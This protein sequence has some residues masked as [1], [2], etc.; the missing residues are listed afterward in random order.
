MKTFSHTAL[1][2]KE[3]RARKSIIVLERISLCGFFLFPPVKNNFKRS[4]FETTEEIKSYDTY[5][6]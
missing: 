3:F 2:I 5:I 1:P 4:Y 6:A